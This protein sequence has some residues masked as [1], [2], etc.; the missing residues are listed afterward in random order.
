MAVM[1]LAD[2]CSSWG[3]YVS[4]SD[5]SFSSRCDKRSVLPPPFPVSFFFLM[6]NLPK[7]SSGVAIVDEAFSKINVCAAL[8]F[9]F[10]F[11]S[12]FFSEDVR[13]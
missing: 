10:F 11:S 13:E 1:S 8:F 3:A 4:L 6:F 2:R 5:A 12:S 7:C 9:F